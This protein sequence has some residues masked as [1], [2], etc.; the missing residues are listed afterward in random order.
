MCRPD[1]SPRCSTLICE[2][3]R[4]G[5]SVSV[6]KGVTDSTKIVACDLSN[7][8]HQAPPAGK[9]AID[10]VLGR[11]AFADAQNGIAFGDIPLRLQ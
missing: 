11:I 2:V 3:L 6:S 8:V 7:W 4:R 5:K 9:I 10:P 1:R